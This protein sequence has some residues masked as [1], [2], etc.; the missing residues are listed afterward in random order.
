MGMEIP[1]RHY[2]NFRSLGKP[3]FLNS[4]LHVVTVPAMQQFS[5]MQRSKIRPEP[6][7]R[8]AARTYLSSVGLGPDEST[9]V[10]A[11]FTVVSEPFSVKVT[12][13]ETSPL[14]AV[15]PWVNSSSVD[16]NTR[17]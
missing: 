4:S 11:P 14:S 8:L 1:R 17:S 5:L 3:L 7:F 6:A 2:I 15:G 10:A 16:F 9:L 12:V 13:A